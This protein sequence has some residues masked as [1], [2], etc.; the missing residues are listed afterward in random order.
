M[1]EPLQHVSGLVSRYLA[2]FAVPSGAT[3]PA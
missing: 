2:R 3:T 1:A